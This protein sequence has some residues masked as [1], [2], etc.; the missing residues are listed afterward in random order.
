MDNYPLGHVDNAVCEGFC[1][2]A[3][4]HILVLNDMTAWCGSDL[5]AWLPGILTTED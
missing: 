4:A 2:V 3:G 1:D 5:E